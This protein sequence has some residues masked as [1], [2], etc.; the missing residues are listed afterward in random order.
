MKIVAPN[1]LPLTTLERALQ[2]LSATL[3]TTL[4]WLVSCGMQ[5]RGSTTTMLQPVLMRMG[6]LKTMEGMKH[7]ADIPR[8]LLQPTTA[9]LIET[10]ST[11]GVGQDVCCWLWSF[12]MCWTE[13]SWRCQWECPV[14]CLLLWTW[15][16]LPYFHYPT[17]DK[18]YL[19][20]FHSGN[21]ALEPAYATGSKPCES[22]PYTHKYCTNNLCCEC[23]VCWCYHSL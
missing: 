22:C 19:H 2:P 20:T 9:E 7:V 1:Q 15:V 5:R 12:Q 13:W 4:N 18:L 10:H 14:P 3:S 21:F 17:C 16:S 6:K 23:C 8:S 11:D